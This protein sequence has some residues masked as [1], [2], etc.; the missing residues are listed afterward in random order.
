[1][2]AHSLQLYGSRRQEVLLADVRGQQ[3]RHI[4]QVRLQASELFGQLIWWLP[5][6]ALR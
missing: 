4:D 1:M 5:V 3:E 6:R 2:C